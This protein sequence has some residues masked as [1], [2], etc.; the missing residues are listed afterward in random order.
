MFYI[1]TIL[2]KKGP[3]AR[4]WLAAHNGKKLS[5]S[6]IMEVNVSKALTIFE[7]ESCLQTSL[8]IQGDLLVGISYITKR[9]TEYMVESADR[10]IQ[11][12]CSL[13]PIEKQS[14]MEKVGKGR[15]NINL[16]DAEKNG[17]LE[18]FDPN[19]ESIFTFD[20]IQYPMKD[21]KKKLL[22]NGDYHFP[23][24]AT[25]PEL[26]AEELSRRRKMVTLDEDF[27]QPNT[28]NYDETFVDNFGGPLVT[29]DQAGGN[30]S[31]VVNPDDNFYNVTGQSVSEINAALNN[32][33]GLNNSLMPSPHQNFEN[34]HMEDGDFNL[35]PPPSIGREANDEPVR[36]RL[37]PSNLI[38]AADESNS[39]VLPQLNN[40]QIAAINRNRNR[41]RRGRPAPI[42][43][44]VM[45]RRLIVDQVVR[46]PEE[47]FRAQLDPSPFQIGLDFPPVFNVRYPNW[48][49]MMEMPSRTLPG[50]LSNLYK[51]IA[52]VGATAAAVD[53]GFVDHFAAPPGSAAP[54]AHQPLQEDDN[55]LPPLN[56]DDAFFGQP[57]PPLP[58]S[59]VVGGK[60][61]IEEQ[62]PNVSF[63]DNFSDYGGSNIDSR[64][65]R[66]FTTAAED[67]ELV[68]AINVQANTSLAA[69]SFTQRMSFEEFVSPARDRR[70]VS[71]MFVNLL[72]KQDKGEVVLQQVSSYNV[73]NTIYIFRYIN[74][75]DDGESDV[76][77]IEV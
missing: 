47:V 14:G 7:S 35:M 58:E 75:G 63:A 19:V 16:P 67:A 15:R 17:K 53:E 61:P 25:I 57:V 33:S 4:L 31:R 38:G 5:K 70:T 37:R 27:I 21:I 20:Q 13:L 11:Q 24:D 6:E 39:L 28:I 76:M 68:A 44:P 48:N 72:S 9:Q 56:D 2:G 52:N 23:D 46:I 18:N 29:N 49:E 36:K 64:R 50:P 73:F 30:S 22:Q 34:T 45:N 54:T 42:V 51:R 40:E 3:L 32:F 43:I 74:E 77:S 26:T 1:P 71:M 12:I 59:P 69:M 65:R 10:T 8:R 62:P 55:F 41:A 66:T 60:H